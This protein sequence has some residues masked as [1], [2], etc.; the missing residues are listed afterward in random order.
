MSEIRDE[1]VQAVVTF[2]KNLGWGGMSSQ[3][4]SR[5]GYAYALDLMRYA[6]FSAASSTSLFSGTYADYPLTPQHRQLASA[7]FAQA[8]TRPIGTSNEAGSSREG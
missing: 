1:D 5:E 6:A 7:L 2:M 8:A 3:D 4:C